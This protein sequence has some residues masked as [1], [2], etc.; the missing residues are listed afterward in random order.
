MLLCTSLDKP[1]P[2]MLKLI[3]IVEI[4]PFRENLRENN[5]PKVTTCIQNLF[6]YQVEQG[7][8]NNPELLKRYT[9]AME[10]QINV[11]PGQGE[12]VADARNTW[13][14]GHHKYW[15]IRIPKGARTDNPN[16]SDYELRFPLGPSLPD[17]VPSHDGYAEAIGMTGWDW[18]HRRSK[19]V[20]FDFDGITGHAKGVGISEEELV[21]VQEA[22]CGIPWVES[23]LST[24][25]GG[26]HLYVY[27]AGPDDPPEAGIPTE[28]H[29]VHAA[30]ARC[31]LGIMSQHAE[32]DFASATDCCGGNMWVWHRD[33]NKGNHGLLQTQEATK[34][35][36]ISKLSENWRDNI[37]VV[38]K[39]RSKVRVQGV[40]DQHTDDLDQL[41]ISR[42]PVKMTDRH[43][44]VIEAL[45]DLATTDNFSTV[46][47]NDYKLFQTHTVALKKVM[48]VSPDQYD[49]FF[50]TNSKGDH[51]DTPNCFMFALP[52]KGFKVYRFSPGIIEH[53][54]W[55]QDGKGWTTCL[56]DRKPTLEL[57]AQM[58]GGSETGEGHFV[59]QSLIDARKCLN[60]VGTDLAINAQAYGHRQGQLRTTRRGRV[61]L[62]MKADKGENHPGS[63]WVEKRGGWWERVIKGVDT[64]S[65][66]TV[67]N[68]TSQW[69]HLIRALKSTADED[70]GWC[71]FDDSERWV[72]QSSTNA[73]LALGQKSKLKGRE[74]DNVLGTSVLGSW[75]LV[76][77]PFH[78]E[79]PGG[80]QWNL[81]AA[82]WKHQPAQL[83]INEAPQHP[84]WDKVLDHVSGDLNTPLK[85][86]AW[87]IKHGVKTGRQ[88]LQMWIA[89]L[90][91][92][93]FDKLPYLFLHGPENC[94][95]ST[96]HM[97]IARLMTD[98]VIPASNA[99]RSES[100]FNGELCNKVLAVV[101]E[102]NPQ[103]RN[104]NLAR[105]RM[106]D[107]TTSDYIA[108][109]RMRMDMY[110]QRNSLHF[111]QCSNDRDSCLASV[112]DTRITMMFVPAFTEVQ[113]VPQIMLNKH[114]E[115]EAPH[116][117]RTLIDLELPEPEGRLRVPFINTA[118][119]ERYE[120]FQK[121]ALDIYLEQH[122]T[123]WPGR[124]IKWQE[125]FNRFHKELPSDDPHGQGYWTQRRVSI[126]LPERYP[127]GRLG[128]ETQFFVG[129]I[130]LDTRKKPTADDL[131]TA[132]Y[133]R[134]TS[135]R[136][137]FSGTYT[138]L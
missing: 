40:D 80:R 75:Q 10:I 125:F 130:V 85:K 95:K 11:T 37:E 19:W 43:N 69:D 20:A 82:Q 67:E 12:L 78:P 42:L 23:R 4:G 81:N 134:S 30:L 7:L 108:I 66:D 59:F 138:S 99:L 83:E 62:W 61:V 16:W 121:T 15:H 111:I 129:N 133:V 58:S 46:W 29:T 79:Y 103:T 109:R 64:K 41:A 84:H 131:K 115:E 2:S 132:A 123:Y 65:G 55:T 124:V 22:A 17:Q 105:A 49:G 87:A 8:V 21:K 6:Q 93:P 68:T 60:L 63:G 18:E 56:F 127:T 32:F 44:A 1:T 57:A 70:A 76:N 92:Y 116:F 117:M 14:D 91:C 73:R 38:T 136:L 89:S 5:M 25:G 107:W 13:D 98:G 86:H 97:A 48:E 120:E 110:R 104:F 33:A 137:V 52:G 90:L 122:C 101:E 118:G 113:E 114:L 119:K 27:F 106:K 74:L 28:N 100:D 54:S 3:K 50:N 96:L 51:P 71:I 47:H 135:R 102:I 26:V 9:P 31:V 36:D 34:I 128:Q 77:M 45:M 35:L 72:R 112:G 126:E 24:R 39:R 88:Y 53:E 94:G